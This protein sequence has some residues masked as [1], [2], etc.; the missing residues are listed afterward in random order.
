LRVKILSILHWPRPLVRRGL[1]F[2]IC[3]EINLFFCQNPIFSWWY[4]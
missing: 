1:V 4:K 3:R 2:L